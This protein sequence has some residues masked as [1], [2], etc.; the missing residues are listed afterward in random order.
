METFRFVRDIDPH[1]TLLASLETTELLLISEARS[2]P[3]LFRKVVFQQ[4]ICALVYHILAFL[5]PSVPFICFIVACGG[6]C[7]R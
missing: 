5:E 7:D 6:Q 1:S 3:T 2:N 4:T